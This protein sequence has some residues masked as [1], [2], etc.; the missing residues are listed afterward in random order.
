MVPCPRAL[1]CVISTAWKWDHQWLA[2]CRRLH[3][4]AAPK[5]LC[6]DNS[7]VEIRNKLSL[8][9]KII[10]LE[11]KKR[12]YLD[13]STFVWIQRLKQESKKRQSR[14]IIPVFVVAIPHFLW[15]T[16][17]VQWKCCHFWCQFKAT[18]A[19]GG[20]GDQ[21]LY[22][23]P[24]R[25]PAEVIHYLQPILKDMC[26]WMHIGNSLLLLFMV[27]MDPILHLFIQTVRNIQIYTVFTYSDH[28]RT[29]Q[30]A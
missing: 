11:Q 5:K 28:Q 26:V 12:W 19:Q 30:A 24:Q 29:Q 17:F 20:D 3:H 7:R 25:S 27:H 23:P 22:C 21:E 15:I 8:N 10:Q 14:N 16:S 9:M 2:V 18:R 4:T 13:V 6:S 1:Q